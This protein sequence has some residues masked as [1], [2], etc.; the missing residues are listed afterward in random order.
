VLV[1]AI[2]PRHADW[3]FVDLVDRDGVPR[4]VEVAFADPA[5]APLAREVRAVQPG[6]GWATPAAQAIRD[7]SPRLLRDMSEELMQWATYDERHLS[8]LRAIRPRSLAAIPLV[9]RDRAIGAVTVIRSVMA[10]GLTEEDLVLLS[11]LA[12]PAALALAD[13]G[14]LEAERAARAAA[15]EEARRER[16]GREAAERAVLRLRRVESVSATLAA[17]LPAAALARVAVQNGLSSLGFSTAFVVRG[18]PSGALEILLSLGRPENP[19]L[20]GDALAADDPSPAA[21][22]FRIQTALWIPSPA[23][24]EQAYPGAFAARDPGE[25]AWAAVPLRVDGRTVGAIG[26]GFPRPRELD[27]DERRTMLTLAQQLAQALERGRLRE[28]ETASRGR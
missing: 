9:A 12:A 1:S 16:A 22:A 26:L 17:P 18:G 4:R 13:G 25:Q 28:L 6:P 23:A 5:L 7:R 8:A 11:E 3:C 24:L 20:E 27:E 10:P 2:V 15:E 19:R 21:E 14:R